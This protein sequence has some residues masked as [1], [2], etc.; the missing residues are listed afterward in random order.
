MIPLVGTLIKR[1][2]V[3]LFVEGLNVP[4]SLPNRFSG[5]D[6]MVEVKGKVS[7]EGIGEQVLSLLQ[8]PQF[9]QRRSR[10]LA[11]MPQAGAADR[12][13]KSV[14]SDIL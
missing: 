4:V 2:A 13:V 11:T 9:H 3:K 14:L 6:L 12:L 1:R 8:S 7:V 5:E 10:L